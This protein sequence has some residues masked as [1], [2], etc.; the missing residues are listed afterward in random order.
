MM[1]I[2]FI[3]IFGL[4]SLAGFSQGNN[5]EYVKKVLETPEV[6]LLYSYYSQDGDNAAVTGGEG[7]EKLTDMTPTIIVSIPIGENNVLTLDAGISAYTSASSSN[8]NPFD[9]NKTASP[10][11]ESSGASRSDALTYFHPTFTHSS[12]DRNV[13]L[14]GNVAVS[15]EYDYF[16]IGFGGGYT[17]LMNEKNTEL[18]ISGQV[19]LDTY[20]PQYPIEL[21]EGFFDDR[22][23]GTGTY[24][25][26][27]NEFNQLNRNSYSISLNFSQI[28]TK[29]FQA[30]LSLDVIFQ[31]GLLSTPHQRVYLQDRGDFYIEE[32]QLADNV[33]K[34]PFNRFK[35]PIGG[36]ISYYLNELIS[37]RAYFRYYYDDWGVTAYTG[38]LEI[39][40]KIS[41][42]FTVF[43]MY[44]YY[45][46]TASDY[47]YPKETALSTYE[48]Y[49]SDYDLSEFDSNQYGFGV[50]YK[51]IFT[52]SKVWKFGLKSI[53]FRF[54]QYERTTGLSASIFELGAKFIM[55]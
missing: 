22:I 43:P 50:T 21:R 39:P 54:N 13:I 23:T 35:V 28:I 4:I 24:S 37:L 1:R 47:F 10:W 15:A 31:E 42:K 53:S 29:R 2:G 17:H 7:T 12:K 20:K 52:Q 6:E 14:S 51:D 41:D 27:F 46:Q 16:S 25:P 26:L 3:L 55:D 33:E 11:V 40:I 32:F 34:L 48:Y 8:I 19:Y 9:G 38:S 49:T 45:T 44:R 18:G 30:S 36:R 5:Q